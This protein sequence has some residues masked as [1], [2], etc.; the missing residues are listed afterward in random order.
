MIKREKY[1]NQINNTLSD[2]DKILFLIG[3]RQ[4][5]KTSLIKSLEEFNYISNH[6]SLWLYG[7]DLALES[8]QS[9]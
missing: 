8:I 2:I 3:A 9:A 7:D 5:G 6:E 4:V 1:L